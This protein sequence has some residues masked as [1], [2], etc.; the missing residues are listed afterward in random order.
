MGGFRH[1]IADVLGAA[2]VGI[3]LFGSILVILFVIGIVSSGNPYGGAFVFIMLP[4]L[5]VVGGVLF[6]L[7]ALLAR[8]GEDE[9]EDDA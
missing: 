4:L 2:G 5:V 3:A 1:F 7:G 9:G 8:G 6:G